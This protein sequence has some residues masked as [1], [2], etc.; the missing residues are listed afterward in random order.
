MTNFRPPEI[1]KNDS[2]YEVKDILVLN[3][4]NKRPTYVN[5]PLGTFS[6]HSHK[7]VADN[8]Y[9]DFVEVITNLRQRKLIRE[10]SPNEILNRLTNPELKVI[11]KNINQRVSGTKEEL[12]QRIATY[13]NEEDISNNIDKSYFVI[14]ELGFKILDKYKNVVW[15]FENEEFIFYFS[16]HLSFKWKKFNE[17]YFMKHWNVDPAQVMIDYYKPKNS[18]VVA[19]IYQLENNLEKFF[20]YAV[21]QLSEDINLTLEKSKQNEWFNI[22]LQISSFHLMEVE[23]AYKDLKIRDGNLKDILNNIYIG[24]IKDHT[25][26]SFNTFKKLIIL[27]LNNESQLYNQ[28]L[29]DL[30]NSIRNRFV[31][32][33]EDNVNFGHYDENVCEEETIL[34]I[35]DQTTTDEKRKEE[36]I[37]E[38]IDELDLDVIKK[39]QAKIDDRFPS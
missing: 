22:G 25:L 23:S 7:S 31:D 21:K 9:I 18:A 39:I 13:A 29:N 3:E 12:V 10:S 4:L 35:L 14:T 20:Y 8:N 32:E 34:Y 30:S 15:I 24:S 5:D 11:L 26:I 6:G 19:R 28:L 2:E 17:Y 37:L 36:M 1:K 33:P 38:L 27:I 16:F